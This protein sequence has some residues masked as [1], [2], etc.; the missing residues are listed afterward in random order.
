MQIPDRPEGWTHEVVQRLTE[1]G[2]SETDL[3]DFKA[4]LQPALQQTKACCAFANTRGGFLIFG[5]RER[6]PAGWQV[7][8]LPPNR[9]FTAEF[10]RRIRA[11]PSI[12]YPPPLL[13]R[14]PDS[15]DRV[16]Y[17]V[18]IPRSPVRPHLP[19]SKDERVF[20]KRTNVGCEQ[21]SLEEVRAEFMQY[22]ERRE[23]LKLLVVELATNLEI[24]RSY[25]SLFHEQTFEPL[26]STVLD[27]MLVDAYSLIQADA[28]LLRTLIQ[29]QREIRKSATRTAL[30][31]AR[32]AGGPSVSG[33]PDGM[34]QHHVM[35]LTAEHS[36]LRISLE[37]ALKALRDRYG[38]VNPIGS[39]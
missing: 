17:V 39:E 15:S 8:G 30:L 31:Y 16:V 4:D 36:S 3:F 18:H 38:L 5:V 20:W 21:M 11:D 33:T 19:T 24:V 1:D 27:R 35:S 2:R 9:E 12:Q 37:Y 22:E 13:L 25:Q 29:I 6:G 26:S 34:L 14:V 7:E 32:M 23:R 10:G 28:D